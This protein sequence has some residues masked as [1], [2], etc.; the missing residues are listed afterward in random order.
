MCLCLSLSGVPSDPL[1]GAPSDPI[2]GAPSEPPTKWG[3]PFWGKHKPYFDSEHADPKSLSD[4]KLWPW[5]NLGCLKY[6]Q[7]HPRGTKAGG[8]SRSNS[9]SNC[10]N[11]SFES[12]NLNGLEQAAGSW[13]TLAIHQV[14]QILMEMIGW[15]YTYP[16]EKYE[17]QLGWWNSQYMER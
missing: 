13:Y 10:G 3:I 2:S 6:P 14:Q 17:S 8:P 7:I 11:R 5:H 1:S 15:W 16:A 4:S 12:N 9:S